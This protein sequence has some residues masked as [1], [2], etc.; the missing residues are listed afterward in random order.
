M[1]FAED[2]VDS[3]VYIQALRDGVIFTMSGPFPLPVLLTPSGSPLLGGEALPLAIGRP[4]SLTLE[5][6]E[7]L[8]TLAPELV[9]FG[10]GDTQIFPAPA[11]MAPLYQ[12]HIGFEV[13]NT[14]AACRT[15]NLLIAEDRN[16]MGVFF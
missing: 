15:F 14:P 3:P 7:Y 12:K 9:L 6:I 13:M 5:Y 8:A 11:L 10:T 16:V 4:S 2:Q 1:H